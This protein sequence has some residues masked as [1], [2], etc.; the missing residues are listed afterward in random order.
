MEAAAQVIFGQ[1]TRL[2]MEERER[3]ETSGHTPLQVL[4]TDE[5]CV[6]TSQP[7]SP[8]RPTPTTDSDSGCSCCPSGDSDSKLTQRRSL[9]AE[10]TR[11][12]RE[13]S[14]SVQTGTGGKVL[15]ERV[16]I[17]AYSSVVALLFPQ[18]CI[19]LFLRH[20]QIGVSRTCDNGSRLE[21]ILQVLWVILLLAC[22]ALICSL[23]PLKGSKGLVAGLSA[24]S[25]RLIASLTPKGP[26]LWQFQVNTNFG[27]I[28]ILVLSFL[29]M[30][31]A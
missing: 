19:L 9:Q 22:T 13:K 10:S 26:I 5:D 1:V 28:K 7:T 18:K 27:Q 14:G 24:A 31:L 30:G 8:S 11:P 25:D 6:N 21:D 17:R 29:A 20:P 2:D 3:V 4:S 16:R 23:I 15:Q 12:L